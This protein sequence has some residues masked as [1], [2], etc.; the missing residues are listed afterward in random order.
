MKRLLSLLFIFLYSQVTWAELPVYVSILP[1][2]YFVERIGGEHVDVSVMVQ[3]G[4]SPATYEPTPQQMVKLS[5]TELYIRIGVPFENVWLPKLQQNNPQLT[6]VDA[7]QDIEL[8]KMP[9][10][11]ELF[12]ESHDGHDDEH[13]DE[14]E[15][16][17]EEHHEDSH[18]G[19]HD[20]HEEGHHDDE[21]DDHEEGH[22]DDEHDDHGAGHHNHGEFDPH[23][24]LNPRLVK[25]MAK[26]ILQQLTKYDAEH[27]AEF[28]QNYTQF[29]QELTEL[30][31]T[32]QQKL[33]TV[34]DKKFM[35]FHPS[36]GY[37]AQQYGLIQIPIEIEGKSPN[38][39]DLARLIS[40]AK[41]Q[42]VKVIMVQKQFSQKAASAIAQAT[43]AQ[44][45]VIDPLAENYIENLLDA[46]STFAQAMK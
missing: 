32:I 24:W 18:H 6:V 37:F 13:H 26:Q 40:Y 8:Q 2:K 42:Q 5:Q 17:E 38:S 20:D 45:I 27:Q 30:D 44:L 7:R 3:A 19:E 23:I 21:H 39:K 28:E 14:H 16:H 46:A 25:V 10:I 31:T 15:G 1:Q 4:H 33:S 9:D 34:N 36:W 22:H 35:V 12:A 11:E 29:I 41:Q 43:Q